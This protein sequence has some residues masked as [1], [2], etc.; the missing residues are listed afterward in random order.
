MYSFLDIVTACQIKVW[1]SKQLQNTNNPS[2]KEVVI[3][4]PNEKPEAEMES[5]HKSTRQI[6][7][8]NL[9][10]TPQIIF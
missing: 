5:A 6:F 8:D 2:E 1:S 9:H 4:S 10:K 7:N 3:K